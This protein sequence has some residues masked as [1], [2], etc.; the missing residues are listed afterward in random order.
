MGSDLEWVHSRK[1][2][3]QITSLT[4]SKWFSG[5]WISTDSGELLQQIKS[6]NPG[7]I[8]RENW[9]VL[10]SKHLGRR[11]ILF[12]EDDLANAIQKTSYRFTNSTFKVLS[13]S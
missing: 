9:K 11:L 2:L 5:I 4:Q 13:D 10:D 12:A 1:Q 6:L 7:P 8:R 3:M